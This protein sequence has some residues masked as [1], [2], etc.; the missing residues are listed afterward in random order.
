M[1]R[2]TVTGGSFH[3]VTS[4]LSDNELNVLRQAY[5]SSEVP[6][7]LLSTVISIKM[8]WQRVVAAPLPA[9]MIACAVG[10]HGVMQTAMR[11]SSPWDVL[12]IGTPIKVFDMG[13]HSCAD[14]TF[15]G[16]C[17]SPQDEQIMVDINGDPDSRRLAYMWNCTALGIIPLETKRV[18]DGVTYELPKVSSE[19]K[20]SDYI[21]TPVEEL[22]IDPAT[23][24]GGELKTLPA[25]ED[26]DVGETEPSGI[27]VGDEVEA[28][29]DNGLVVGVFAGLMAGGRAEILVDGISKMVDAD[30]VL[31]RRK[32]E[33]N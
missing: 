9:E 16:R 19:V 10:I 5:G 25:A 13:R 20:I 18:A 3:L 32:E 23:D 33:D 30:C 26:G 4:M 6:Q 11:P 2:A 22:E 7:K 1:L 15:Q 17:N 27:Q 28:V 8:A 21:G 29:S 12:P 14:A 24:L 31:P